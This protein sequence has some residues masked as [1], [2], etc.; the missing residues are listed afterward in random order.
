MHDGF[1]TDHE[2]DLG[3]RFRC[4]DE[5]AL[6]ELYDR[7]ARAVFRLAIRSL[8]STA[9][10][11]DVTQATFVAAWQGRRTFDTDR[12][13][14][15]GWLLG[16]A[17]HQVV[18][19]LRARAREHRVAEATLA[20]PDPLSSPH[21][22]PDRVVDRLLV[23]DGLAGLPAEQRRVLELAFYADLT[24]QQISEVTGQPLGTVKSHIRRGMASLKRRL[25]S[26]GAA[27]GARS[28]GARRGR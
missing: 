28:A 20:Q 15:L 21:D 13:S 10:A 18:D 14:L 9:E 7:Y 23:A 16:I 3:Q 26:S 2:D 8:P 5:Y 1:N 19:R 22:E 25:E 27:P 6:R 12:G 24:H 4:G 11:E 17:R